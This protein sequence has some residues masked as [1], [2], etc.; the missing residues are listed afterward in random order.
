MR[1][2]VI[3]GRGYVGR[4]LTPHL[5][6]RHG[7]RVLDLHPSA[8]VVG[9]ATDLSTVESAMDGV[10]AVVHC[11]MAGDAAPE[12]ASFDVNV[13]SVHLALLAAHRAGVPHAVHISSMSVYDQLTG[14]RLDSEAVP[15]DATDLYGLT[16]RLGE[17]VCA[18]AVRE[19]GISVN[20]L[21]LT[22]PT[23]DET[24]PAWARPDPPVRIHTNAG[25]PVDGTAASDLGRAVLAALDYRN[26]FH[27]FTI[28]G[29]RARR[30]STAK[31]Q[32]LLGWQPTFGFRT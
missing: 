6:A 9:D 5:A 10:D 13:T 11:A 2:L 19:W 21:R 16:K 18:A 12:R 27:V 32:E 25:E 29:D 3:G 28:S 1:V 20:S 23:P 4:L 22:W 14:R 7:V 30:W 15:T 8:D 17:Q 31:A 24:W 26:G